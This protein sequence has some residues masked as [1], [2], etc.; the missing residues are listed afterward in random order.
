MAGGVL[1]KQGVAEQ[2]PGAADGRVLP[3]QGHLAQA[4]GALIGVQQ[5]LDDVRPAV[6][7]E[8]HHLA[9]PE[10]E[11][12]ALNQ[13]APR[14]QG[15]GGGQGA[16]HFVGVGQGEDLLGGQVGHEAVP[17]RNPGG[18]PLP[19]MPLGQVNHQVGARALVVQLLKVVPVQKIHM[20]RQRLL[21]GLPR[22]HRVL[23][24]DAGGLKNLLPQGTDGG[25]LFQLREHAHSPGRG[26]QG[27]DAPLDL[28]LHGVLHDALVGLALDLLPAADARR[29]GLLEQLRVGRV[30]RQQV[31]VVQVG[32]L[33]EVREEAGHPVKG[34]IRRMQVARQGEPVILEHQLDVVGA[35]VIGLAGNLPRQGQAVLVQ[36]DKQ[37]VPR[38]D[39]EPHLQNQLCV[40]DQVCLQVHLFLLRAGALVSMR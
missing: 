40:F 24:V 28:V 29:V 15:Q 20:A 31:V 3:H 39:V 27:R 9:V 4:S 1:I 36:A 14:A 21:V 6:R 38:L 2:Q 23:Q 16:V 35:Q 32:C 34:R 26:G 33:A 11:A 25:R 12:Q 30:E 22:G 7:R 13:P 5:A 8:I 17:A 37:L 10:G 18:T 19:D